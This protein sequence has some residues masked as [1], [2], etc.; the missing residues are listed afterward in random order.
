MR[1]KINKFQF[2]EQ[3]WEKGMLTPFCDSAS[4]RGALVLVATR[5]HFGADVI[6]VINY[7]NAATLPLV[8]KTKKQRTPTRS[9]LLFWRR[10]K[11]AIRT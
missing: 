8:P 2:V 6:N 3:S 5:S 10:K 11:E 1:F 7:R 9:V 4:H